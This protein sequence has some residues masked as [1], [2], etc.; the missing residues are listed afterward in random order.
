VGLKLQD[1]SYSA[2][3][4]VKVCGVT[5]PEDAL[6]AA[7]SGAD[8]IG[9]IVWPNAKRSIDVG[10]AKEITAAAREGG[11]EPV[12][13]FVS[14]NSEEVIRTRCAPLLANK[15]HKA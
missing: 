2:Q 4:Q 13:V 9:M 1:L 3:S 6:Y 5:D 7:K 15:P 8:F 12:G 11:A 14:E 10:L